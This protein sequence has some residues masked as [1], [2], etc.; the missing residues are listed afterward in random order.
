MPLFTGLYTSQVVQGFLPS[1]VLILA[2]KL[3]NSKKNTSTYHGH[4]E[5]SFFRILSREQS[6]C[7]APFVKNKNKNT[8]QKPP[9][10]STKHT[11]P[12]GMIWEMFLFQ[13]KNSPQTVPQ[14]K[15]ST[16]EVSFEP[17]FQRLVR[18]TSR[19]SNGEET[20]S[21]V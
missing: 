13:L 3:M 21:N 11:S 10:K 5:T 2:T 7:L 4:D 6:H 9:H 16:P 14:K 20:S 18:T 15:T 8:Q 19:R 17:E 12:G 1:T